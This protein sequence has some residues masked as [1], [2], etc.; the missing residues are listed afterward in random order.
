MRKL[1]LALLLAATP[2]AQAPAQN[3]LNFRDA[4]VRAFIEDAARVT[5]RTFIVD[6]AVQGKVSVV[7]Q[8]P[9]SRSEYFEL[10][11]ST[12][13]ANGLIAVPLQNGAFR[14][15]PSRA[16]RRSHPDSGKKALSCYGLT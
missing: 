8:R 11:L 9:L 16:R 2:L 7:T 3:V 4:D 10:F 12:L 5:G 6:P 1:V 13:R 14:I 15:Q